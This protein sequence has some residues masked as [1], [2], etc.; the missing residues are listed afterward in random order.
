[1]SCECNYSVP[2]CDREFNLKASSSLLLGAACLSRPITPRASRLDRRTINTRWAT[3][4]KANHTAEYDVDMRKV[5]QQ[6]SYN[7]HTR[8]SLMTT[9]AVQYPS[10]RLSAPEELHMI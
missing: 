9:D 3:C 10:D 2:C 1:M 5:L 7:Q 6:Q 8:D 4:A